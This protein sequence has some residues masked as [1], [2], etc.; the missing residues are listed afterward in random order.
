MRLG[1]DTLTLAQ[2]TTRW[3][4][5]TVQGAMNN[6]RK[7]I[8]LRVTCGKSTQSLM[9]RDLGTGRLI[10]RQSRALRARL[11]HELHVTLDRRSAQRAGLRQSR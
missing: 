4:G 10:T 6:C 8:H 11:G 5:S 7:S 9:R 2:A 3:G 1:M